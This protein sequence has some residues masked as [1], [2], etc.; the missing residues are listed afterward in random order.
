MKVLI[1]GGSFNPLT[2]AHISVAK[3][4]YKNLSIDKLI[5][6]PTSTNF[7]KNIKKYNQKDII[8]ENKRIFLLNELVNNVK[9][10]FNFE[11]SLLEINNPNFKTFDSLMY[12]K[13]KYY[14]NDV[15]YFAMGDEKLSNFYKWYKAK[16]ILENFKI[17][18]IKRVGIDFDLFYKNK[19]YK[20][21]KNQFIFF[22]P[23]LELSNISSTKV[24]NNMI[25]IDGSLEVKD[26]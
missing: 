26:V 14:Q 11:L 22:G 18:I 23:N 13:N 16:E 3:S 21:Y 7:I 17:V 9:K 10:E 1:F 4:L 5:F 8:E 6:L 24:R 2:F 15:I 20:E 19:L 25:K 12:F